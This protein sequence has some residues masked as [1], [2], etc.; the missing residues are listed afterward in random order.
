MKD[1]INAV[2]AELEA[3]DPRGVRSSRKGI[4][5]ATRDSRGNKSLIFRRAEGVIRFETWY[6]LGSSAKVEY[7]ALSLDQQRRAAAILDRLP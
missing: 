3:S 6:D 7:H 4:C 5:A 2:L 1:A